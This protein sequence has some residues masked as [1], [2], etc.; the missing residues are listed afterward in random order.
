VHRGQHQ[1]VFQRAQADIRREFGAVLAQPVKL[2]P[3]AHDAAGGA[4]GIVGALIQMGLAETRRDQAFD[5]EA[6]QLLR[7]VAEQGFEGAV[8]EQKAAVGTGNEHR[9]RRRLQQPERAFSLQPFY[10]ASTPSTEQ[11]II[12]RLAG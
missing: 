3:G 9:I 5:G 10:H 4:L 6:G 12:H 8:R 11:T 7:G 2:D 1:P